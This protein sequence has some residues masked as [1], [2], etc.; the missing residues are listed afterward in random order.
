MKRGWLRQ[1]KR[2][3]K[4]AKATASDS[5]ARQLNKSEA[6][7]QA[8]LADMFATHYRQDILCLVPFDGHAVYVDPRDSLIASRLLQGRTWHIEQLLFAIARAQ[9]LGCFTENGVFVDVGA[10]IGTQTNY[11]LNSGKF[12]SA[13]CLEA[14][15]QT[16]RVLQKNIALNNLA[17]RVVAHE[18]AVS[19]IEGRQTLYRHATNFGANSLDPAMHSSRERTGSGALVRTVVLDSFLANEGFNFASIGMILMDIEGHELTALEGMREVMRASPPL[20]LEY[21]GHVHGA[22]GPSRLA[23]LLREHYTHAVNVRRQDPALI[24]LEKMLLEGRQYDFLFV[25]IPRR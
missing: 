13:V 1:W 25:R 19:D 17:L 12:A 7:R 6:F 3:L 11:A 14:D 16:F 21:S 4:W 10:N 20:L 23:G 18:V 22:S 5:V 24:P 2:G 15:P 9:E 8:A